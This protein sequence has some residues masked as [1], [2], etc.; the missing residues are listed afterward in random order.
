[1]RRR[2]PLVDLAGFAD[3]G[4]GVAQ[5]PDRQIGHDEGLRKA[6]DRDVVLGRAAALKTVADQPAGA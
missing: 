1:L 5:R 2:G 4:R 3:A 6:L